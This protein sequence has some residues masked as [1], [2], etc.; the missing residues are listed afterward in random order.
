[1]A[2]AA[3]LQRCA[4]STAR[5]RP[6]PRT[7]AAVCGQNPGAGLAFLGASRT[8]ERGYA[9]ECT[10]HKMWGGPDLA[11]NRRTV[12]SPTSTPCSPTTVAIAPTVQASPNPLGPASGTGEAILLVRSK[13]ELA[14]V[15]GR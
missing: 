7:S 4:R 14:A 15:C 12:D 6:F 11:T 13:D 9:L 3:A 5:E 10:G 8:C 2:L 1:M